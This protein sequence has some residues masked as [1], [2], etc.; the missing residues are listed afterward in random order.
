MSVVNKVRQFWDRLCVSWLLASSLIISAL[1]VCGVVGLTVHLVQQERQKLINDTQSANLVSARLLS[2]QIYRVFQECDLIMTHI[3]D[4]L[5]PDDP[6]LTGI[7]QSEARRLT[8][9]MP[10][11]VE[12]NF[13]NAK[14]EVTETTAYTRHLVSYQDR[15]W[16]KKLREGG[17]EIIID[18]PFMSPSSAMRVI[19]VLRPL[20][21]AK[22]RNM[23][24]IV[25]F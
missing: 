21:D 12:V 19:P 8:A 23:G 16:F 17:D 7:A 6:A 5:D 14:G 1:I 9:A 25:V 20:I 4:G 3:K 18:A 2:E 22:G 10:E 11:I 15:P 24:A 13:I